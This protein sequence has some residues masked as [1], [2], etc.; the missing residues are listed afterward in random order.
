[1][2]RLP[3]DIYAMWCLHPTKGCLHPAKGCPHPAKGCSVRSTFNEL[4]HNFE[5]ELENWEF[6]K[7]KI[8]V[9][10][11]ARAAKDGHPAWVDLS[12]KSYRRT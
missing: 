3:A 11:S 4:D 1:M 5:L 9:A 12:V 8:W 7:C 2:K 6:L 10:T